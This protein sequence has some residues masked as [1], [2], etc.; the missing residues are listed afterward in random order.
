MSQTRPSP[1]P[2]SLLAL[3]LLGACWGEA[4]PPPQVKPSLRDP[5]KAGPLKA[6]ALFE[7]AP[8][9]VPPGVWGKSPREALDSVV[10]KLSGNGTKRSWDFAKEMLQR[11]RTPEV[12]EALTDFLQRR[13]LT[14][15]DQPVA[16]NAIQVM[17]A[18]GDPVHAEVLLEATR[19]ANRTVREE[20]CRAL[21]RSGT[22]ATADELAKGFDAVDVREQALRL[23]VLM[24]QWPAAKAVPFLRD[25]ITGRRSPGN[26]PVLRQQVRLGFEEGGVDPAIIRGTLEGNLGHYE[27]AA[28][29]SVASLL[30]AAGSDEGRTVLLQELARAKDQETL[31]YVIGGLSGRAPEE[32]LSAV[33]DRLAALEV[34]D[35]H[36]QA[37]LAHLLGAIGGENEVA[38]LA[39]MTRES[40]PAVR[41]AAWTALRG[42]PVL[43]DPML[44]AL[45]TASGSRLRDALQEAHAYRTP[46][47]VPVLARRLAEAQGPDKRLFIQ[48]LGFLRVDEAVAP[49][50]EVIAGDPVWLGDGMGLETCSYA[51]ELIANIPG[52]EGGL[53]D[54]LGRLGEDRIRRSLVLEALAK[55]AMLSADEDG[56]ARE[57]ADP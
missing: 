33:D 41:I 32:S 31:V 13:L 14:A 21:M 40:H 5:L 6:A 17:S 30:H 54:L 15:Q 20:A 42:H 35:P 18:A 44:E 12:V 2:L 43:L 3:A 10:A 57:E 22:E 45:A 4:P 49:L 36:L 46:A 34:D 48:G 51:A 9:P 8:A 16:R 26:T 27:G 1:K 24:K 29:L 38:R 53:W 52:A 11:V 55:L 19:H 39:T 37:A 7:Q 28:L 25:L 50:C 47:A 23:R 56:L